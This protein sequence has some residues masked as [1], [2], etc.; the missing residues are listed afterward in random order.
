MAKKLRALTRN[1][2]KIKDEIRAE[3]AIELSNMEKRLRIEF[4]SRLQ[5]TK[6]DINNLQSYPRPF[7]DSRTNSNMLDFFPISIKQ[8]I[9]EE[10]GNSNF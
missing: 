8:E 4:L 1:I 10:I 9:K 5:E 6:N 7:D 3:N 2:R